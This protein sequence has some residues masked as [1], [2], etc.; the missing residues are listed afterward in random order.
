MK[1]NKKPE[2]GLGWF[3]IT[4]AKAEGA[5]IHRSVRNDYPVTV[6]SISPAKPEGFSDI[7]SVGVVYSEKLKQDPKYPKPVQ[8]STRSYSIF[9]DDVIENY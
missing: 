1:D 4:Q 9:Y 7:K 2:T 8:S 6:S 5:T 3:S